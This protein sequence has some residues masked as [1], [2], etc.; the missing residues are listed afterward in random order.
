MGS[1]RNSLRPGNLK[2][3]WSRHDWLWVRK[4]FSSLISP[5]ILV[6]FCSADIWP[7]PCCSSGSTFSLAPLMWTCVGEGHGPLVLGLLLSLHPCENGSREGTTCSKRHGYLE[8]IAGSMHFCM[9]QGWKGHFF[10]TALLGPHVHLWPPEVFWSQLR[11][12]TDVVQL[13]SFGALL[14]DA[15]CC[16]QTYSALLA[17]GLWERILACEATDPTSLAVT[18]SSCPASPN[19][20]ST[21]YMGFSVGVVSTSSQVLL[22][23]EGRAAPSEQG[24]GDW[25]PGGC[26]RSWPQ[27]PE[28]QSLESGTALW[29]LS[30]HGSFLIKR[31]EDVHD[32]RCC[33]VATCKSRSE[34]RCCLNIVISD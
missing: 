1:W 24:T 25:I 8:Q 31:P 5:H 18:R 21:R 13:C 16:H 22:E 3:T 7:N 9:K 30:R 11:V 26:Q 20:P 6:F 33:L 4:N 19:D 2:R 34:D 10:V 28:A 15:T 17:W 12:G 32:F 14:V 23:P 27:S 29:I